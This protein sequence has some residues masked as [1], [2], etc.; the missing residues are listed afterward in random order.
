M[1]HLPVVIKTAILS[2]VL[3]DCSEDG[4]LGIKRGFSVLETRPQAK[5]QLHIDFLFTSHHPA[6]KFVRLKNMW[7]TKPQWVSTAWQPEHFS[8]RIVDLDYKER[9]H[10]HHCGGGGGGLSDL[11]LAPLV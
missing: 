1:S 4:G 6:R 5:Q 8:H 9:V 10:I 3:F 2:G 11:F 7:R